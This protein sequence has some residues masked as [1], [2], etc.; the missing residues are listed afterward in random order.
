MT[1]PVMPSCGR[2]G[3]RV[4]REGAG[5]PYLFAPGVHRVPTSLAGEKPMSVRHRLAVVVA[6]AAVLSGALVGTAGPASAGPPASTFGCQPTFATLDPA[7]SLDERI[8]VHENVTA[9]PWTDGV[10][11]HSG[12]STMSSMSSTHLESSDRWYFRSLMVRNGSLTHAMTSYPNGNPE[13]RSTTLRQYGR[14]WAPVTR[15]VDATDR[16]TAVT[17]NGYLYA[18]NPTAGTL[19]RYRVVEGRSFGDLTVTSAGSAAGYGGFRGLTLAYRLRAGYAGVADV[20]LATTRAGALYQI[21]ISNT[22]AYAPKLTLLR[23]SS[24]TFDQLAVVQCDSSAALLGVRTATDEASL[25]RVDSFAGTSSVIRGYGRF[26]TAP[27]TAT[28]TV[29]SWYGMSGPSRW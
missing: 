1:G 20:L 10:A 5:M 27:W 29:G 2:A 17:K 3:F 24:W 13:L 18:L 11:H 4:L 26:G 23:A 25:Y 7:G 9:T 16:G 22:A 8:A 12:V 28:S 6:A 14:G 19:A 21:T 15:L